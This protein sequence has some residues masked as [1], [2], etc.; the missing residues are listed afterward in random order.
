MVVYLLESEKKEKS[1][2]I[3][4]CSKQTN[5]VM[6]LLLYCH[7]ILPIYTYFII[8]SLGHTENHILVCKCHEMSCPEKLWKGRH[9]HFAVRAAEPHRTTA[10]N[11]QKQ[12]LL[13]FLALHPSSLQT[14]WKCGGRSEVAGAFRLFQ[15]WVLHSGLTAGPEHEETAGKS[16]F[17]QTHWA[18][19]L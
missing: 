8:F 1:I 6:L 16:P 18:A 7:S 11:S 10:P 19:H 3:V 9:Q 13:G 4:P 5:M 2:T 12:H 17:L 15:A 14:T